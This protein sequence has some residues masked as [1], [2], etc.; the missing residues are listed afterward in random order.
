MVFGK[1]HLMARRAKTLPPNAHWSNVEN[2]AVLGLTASVR[3]RRS[4]GGS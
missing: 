1:P 4:D 2:G 3:L